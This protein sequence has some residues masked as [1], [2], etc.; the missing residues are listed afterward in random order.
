MPLALR[1]I[2]GAPLS[3][4]ASQLANTRRAAKAQGVTNGLPILV[5]SSGSFALS[6]GDFVTWTTNLAT[7]QDIPEASGTIA[8]TGNLLIDNPG[9]SPLNC[10]GS[11]TAV[12]IL[13]PMGWEWGPDSSQ[14]K[15]LGK[16]SV[17]ISFGDGTTGQTSDFIYNGWGLSCNTGWAYIAGS[18]VTQPTQ[19]TSDVYADCVHGNI[20]FTQGAIIMASPAQ[21][22]YGRYETIFPTLT[23][24][25][26]LNSL[27]ANAP[28]PSIAQGEVFG[29][30]TRDGGFAKVYF[31]SG[32]GSTTVISATGMALHSSPDGSYAY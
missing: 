24:A 18:I 27:F 8:T 32:A 15:P 29:V 20:V 6:A 3:A 28:M 13:H 17:T 4:T 26:I 31:T 16:Q 19:A 25:F 30:I 7:S 22:Q 21:D 5:E 9:F 14:T 2:G 11:L 12:C 23:A 1:T 10:L